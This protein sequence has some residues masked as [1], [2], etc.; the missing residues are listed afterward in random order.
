MLI[1]DA[2]LNL[3]QFFTQGY[4]TS[5][6]SL[7]L[8][9][10]LLA[11][12]RTQ[13]FKHPE[14]KSNKEHPNYHM[15]SGLFYC[16]CVTE[17]TLPKGYGA[18]TPLMGMGF[19]EEDVP[20][21]NDIWMR[22]A[23]EPYFAYFRENFGSFTELSKQMNHHRKGEGLSWH[24]DHSDSTF[25]INIIFLTEDTFNREDGGTLDVGI[26]D[27]YHSEPILLESIPPS[28]G[29]MVTINNMNPHFRHSVPILKTDK[30]RY[31]LISQFG[32][33]LNVMHSLREKKWNLL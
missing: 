17:F 10:E 19:R 15:D 33:S 27:A 30:S 23:G 5:T 2:R 24:T 6:L 22:I 9:D 29:L 13:T 14:K 8:A 32:Y 11:R 21:F 1:Q 25:L 20:Y 28:H 4:A 12:I 18:N 7:A 26:A 3:Q 16:D 31:S